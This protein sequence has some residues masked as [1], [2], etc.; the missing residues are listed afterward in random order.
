M[1]ISTTSRFDIVQLRTLI[2]QALTLPDDVVIPEYQPQNK[3]SNVI[4]VNLV[5]Q[6]EIGVSRL[7]FDGEKEI[8]KSSILSMVSISCYGKNGVAMATKLKSVTNATRFRERLRSI[9]GAILRYSDVR[10]L[11]YI[12]GA[13][14]EERGQFDLFIVHDH[15]TEVALEAIGQTSIFVNQSN[16]KTVKK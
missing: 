1:D 2:A 13:A 9:G 16:F 8:I 11:T 5:T 4:T 12:L 7:I 3:R 6:Q 10:N 14:A 15:V